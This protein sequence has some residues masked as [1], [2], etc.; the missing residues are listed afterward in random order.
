MCF[1][2]SVCM[3]VG[4]RVCVSTDQLLDGFLQFVCLS[5]FQALVGWVPPVCLFVCLCAELLLDGFLKCV[6]LFF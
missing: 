1:S 4:L 3:C 2:V 6:C 5:E